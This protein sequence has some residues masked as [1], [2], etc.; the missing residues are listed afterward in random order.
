MAKVLKCDGCGRELTDGQNLADREITIRR[1][2][3]DTELVVQVFAGTKDIIGH[4]DVCLACVQKMV[5]EFTLT[6]PV[7]EAAP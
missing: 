5:K 7:S 4:G 6:A 1:R 2:L 3:R